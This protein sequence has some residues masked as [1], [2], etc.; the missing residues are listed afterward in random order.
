[1]ETNLTDIHECIFLPDKDTNTITQVYKSNVVYISNLKESPQEL[2]I[3]KN[4]I[5]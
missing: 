4:R 3:E 5:F 1:M 2:Y